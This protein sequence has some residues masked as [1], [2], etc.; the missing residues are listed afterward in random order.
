M[1]EVERAK[2]TVWFWMRLRSLQG[3]ATESHW[4][5]RTEVLKIFNQSLFKSNWVSLARRSGNQA[6]K[7]WLTQA[8]LEEI[9]LCQFLNFVF[10][11]HS[12]SLNLLTYGTQQISDFIVPSQMNSQSLVLFLRSQNT[13][14]KPTFFKFNMGSCQFYYGQ[15]KFH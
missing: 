6:N 13:F 11:S 3:P 12:W 9:F 10:S 4:E 2:G 14:P 5:N 15:M 1:V 8:N 7:I